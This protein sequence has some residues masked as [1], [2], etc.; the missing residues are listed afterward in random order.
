[1][2]KRLLAYAFAI[3]KSKEQAEDLVQDAIRRAFDPEETA[4]NP[5]TFPD[6]TFFL[7]SLVRRNAS[8]D[9]AGARHHHEIT[10]QSDAHEIRVTRAAARVPSA[11]PTPEAAAATHDLFTRRLA[12][13]RARAAADPLVLSLV[14][15]MESDIETPAEQVES[16]S[17]PLEDI[18]RAR[19]RL[20]DHAA[21]VARDLPDDGN[22]TTAEDA[23]VAQ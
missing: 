4:W 22:V 19:R 20:F 13:L 18:R 5:V 6:V 14:D 2:Q 17:V 15:A 10:V 21:I 11:A 16:L 9:R 23:E 3:T 12:A 7:M 8:N 1:V